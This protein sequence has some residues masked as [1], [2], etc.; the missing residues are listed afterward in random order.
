MYV[1]TADTL[2][3]PIVLTEEDLEKEVRQCIP[4][5]LE[6]LAGSKFGGWG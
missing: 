1:H 2:R 3:E 5:W 4:V 6:I